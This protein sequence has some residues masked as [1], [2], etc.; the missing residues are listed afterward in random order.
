[1]RGVLFLGVPHGGTEAASWAS[2]L[3]CTA[4][5]RGSSTTLL[6]YLAPGSPEIKSL[7]MEF[8]YSY[9]LQRTYRK[10]ILPRI[11]DFFELRPEKIGPFVLG[12]VSLI[13]A[14]TWNFHIDDLID[15]Q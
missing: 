7:E 5:W 8:H 2:L 11:V 4:Y 12:L 1:M 3:A 15:L 13:P 9:V 10:L 14:W 6:E